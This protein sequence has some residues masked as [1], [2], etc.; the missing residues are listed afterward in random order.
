M[1]GRWGAWIRT[2]VGRLIKVQRWLFKRRPTGI[3]QSAYRECHSPRTLTQTNNLGRIL[4]FD[5]LLISQTERVN[6]T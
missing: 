1:T 5:A 6:E 2:R 4:A 3:E